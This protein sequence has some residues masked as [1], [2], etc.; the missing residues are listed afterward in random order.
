MAAL[1]PAGASKGLMLVSTAMS[2]AGQ[3][4]QAKAT[5]A[6]YDEKSAATILQ[7]RA[8]AARYRLQGAQVLKSLNEN[9]A[10]LINRSGATGSGSIDTIFQASVAE[11]S[12]EYATAQDNVIL[13]EGYALEQANQ[14]TQAGDSARSAA[15]YGMLTTAAT[16]AFR[17][18]ML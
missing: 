17:Y 8:E 3:R 4:K 15:R 10:T 13:A 2:I 9:L 11:A 7:G 14:Y 12:T 5:E 18:G 1:L 6:M 16:G